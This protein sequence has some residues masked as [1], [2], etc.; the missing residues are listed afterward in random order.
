[1]IFRFSV[2]TSCYYYFSLLQTILQCC[3]GNRTETDTVVFWHHR[4]PSSPRFLTLKMVSVC[5][6]FCPATASAH[7]A[8]RI[9]FGSFF[10]SSVLLWHKE[11]TNYI[12]HPSQLYYGINFDWQDFSTIRVSVLPMSTYAYCMSKYA[13]KQLIWTKCLKLRNYGKSLIK[14]CPQKSVSIKSPIN[15][16]GNAHFCNRCTD[17]HYHW[18]IA[19][20]TILQCKELILF[21]T[22]LKSF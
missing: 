1:M 7:W 22:Q 4:V 14:V 13:T 2:S 10:A 19:Q 9:L 16:V 6:Q 17:E 3:F 12:S 21:Q 11:W 8:S 15:L 20:S 5:L 18:K